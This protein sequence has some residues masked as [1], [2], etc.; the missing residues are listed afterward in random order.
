[1]RRIAGDDVASVLGELADL[2]LGEPVHEPAGRLVQEPL[3]DLSPAQRPERTT[4]P[5]ASTRGSPLRLLATEKEADEDRSARGDLLDSVKNGTVLARIDQ[6]RD[7]APPEQHGVERG[8]RHLGERPRGRRHGSH[9]IVVS[10]LVHREI[11]Q[12]PRHLACPREEHIVRLEADDLEASLGE[13]PRFASPTRRGHEP[14]GRSLAWSWGRGERRSRQRRVFPIE[15]AVLVV[16]AAGQVRLLRSIRLLRHR[17]A[18]LGIEPREQELI[19]E[20]FLRAVASPRDAIDRLHGAHP[21]RYASLRLRH[22]A[23]S[24]HRLP[25][26]TRKVWRSETIDAALPLDQAA[27]VSFAE[28]RR[29]VL[30]DRATLCALLSK[31]PEAPGEA[32]DV[33]QNAEDLPRLLRYAQRHGVLPVIACHLQRAVRPEVAARLREIEETRALSHA[34]GRHALAE[35]LAALAE[36][37]VRAVSLKGPLLGERLYTP[38]FARPSVDLDLLV[39]RADFDRAREALARA[40]WDRLA[41]A[42]EHKALAVHHHVQLLSPRHPSLELHF[43][44]TS[45]FGAV[46]TA[47]PLIA[48]ATSSDAL[49]VPCL[50]LE[51]ADELVYLATHAAAHRFERL[52]WLF[53]LALALRPFEHRPHDLEEVLTRAREASL[54]RVVTATLAHAASCFGLPNAGVWLAARLD[55]GQRTALRAAHAFDDP[56]VPESVQSATRLAFVT[57][58]TDSP[59]LAA[60]HVAKKLRKRA[61]WRT[62]A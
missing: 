29:A 11:R 54:R 25:T 17:V 5:A 49:G 14:A 53:D 58:L 35:A 42:N 18:K 62:G 30:R 43:A 10:A 55:R 20:H 45:S 39:A 33:L 36:D 15:E 32:A 61:S 40:S 3:S 1:M 44:A 37:E 23:R 34:V 21:E 52:G 26:D 38:P 59:A 46:L 47:E 16:E 7:A 28:R 22:H 56:A 41:D 9:Q 48:R 31:L 2:G 19:A 50:V 12:S 6:V 60:R 51:H 13:D 27:V 8:L 4:H 24:L 57:A